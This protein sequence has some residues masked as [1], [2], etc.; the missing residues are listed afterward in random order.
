MY[1]EIGD[2]R[3]H[4]IR[5]GKKKSFIDENMGF[6]DTFATVLADNPNIPDAVT[7]LIERINSQGMVAVKKAYE[8][9]DDYTRFIKKEN[10]ALSD[11]IFEA[12][13]QIFEQTA[14]NDLH[15][16]KQD[17]LPIPSSIKISS[18]F[19]NGISNEQF[20]TAFSGLQKFV[21]ACYDEIEKA[22]F[23]WGYPDFYTTDG[24]YNRVNDILFAMTFFGEYRDDVLTV[25]G[26]KFFA[27]SGIKR[28]KKVELVVSGFERM[29]L[30]F[31][32]FDKKSDTFCV[33]Y[34][35]NPLVL[36]ALCAY[37]SDI[38]ENKQ[39]WSYGTP[40]HGFSYRFVE[41]PT[42][43]THETVFLAEFDYMSKELQEI[44]LWLH[45]EA[46]KCGFFIDPN[47]P[48]DKGCIRYKKGSKQWLLVGHP[49]YSW[50]A[51]DE[52]YAKVI[53]RDVLTNDGML[54]LYRRFP[55]TFRSNCRGCNG[56]N[57]CTMRIEFTVDRQPRRCC[58]Y[59]S[60]LLKNPT[61]DDTKLILELFKLENNIK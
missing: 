1:F 4:L 39:H 42:T 20:V 58:A 34:F 46:A 43:Q 50:M 21:I 26:N 16:R 48:L 6:L 30:S 36:H 31:D 15:E 25:D 37:M 41:C 33:T 54:E 40:R 17:I 59:N 52:I 47:E 61:L 2:Y 24:Y 45:A 10:P 5:K 57:P 18:R 22:P 56:N 28:H 51:S 55:D 13:Q 35:E 9:L 11:V 23:G 32:S 38:D 7:V 27:Y 3:E 12:C 8:F 53:F 19:L 60:F 14:K 44:Q 49:K 29:G